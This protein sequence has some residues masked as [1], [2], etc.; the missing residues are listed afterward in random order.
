M[1]MPASGVSKMMNMAVPAALHL[2]DH[3]VLEHHLGDAAALAAFEERCVAHVLA[4][5]LEAQPGRQQHAERH[6]HAQQLLVLADRFVEYHGQ[7]DIRPVFGGDALY[8]SAFLFLG[9]GRRAAAP[10]AMRRASRA[11][12]CRVRWRRARSIQEA[13][14]ASTWLAN[15]STIASTAENLSER[16]VRGMIAGS[17]GISSHC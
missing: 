9:A 2:V 7:S 17:E 14:C 6:H 11:P 8:Q 1:P 12:R 13:P 15:A 3:L 16:S 10:P 4:I 5:D